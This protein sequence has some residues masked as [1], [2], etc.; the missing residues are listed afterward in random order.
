MPRL[1]DRQTA[2]GQAIASLL[3]RYWEDQAFV[4]DFRRVKEPHRERHEAWCI[5][6]FLF[7]Y[8]MRAALPGDRYRDLLRTSWNTHVL[9]KIEY[10]DLPEDPREL[11]GLVQRVIAGNDS[12]DLLGDLSCFMG[13]S[14]AIARQLQPYFD[15]LADLADRW[16]LRAPWS[17]IGLCSYD[18]FITWSEMP[19]ML[20][21]RGVNLPSDIPKKLPTEVE[22]DPEGSFDILECLVPPWDS[23]PPLRLELHAQTLTSLD[24]NNI[25]RAVR[26]KVWAFSMELK[27]SGWH[28]TP[29]ATEKHAGW[30]FDHYVLARSFKEIADY[31]CDKPG[32]LDGDAVRKAIRSFS[33]R[34]DCRPCRRRVVY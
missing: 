20:K 10:P 34:I 29:S 22:L 5:T 12:G 15:G 13:L 23:T 17:V 21:D 19:Q 11:E 28:E 32:G 4:A 24:S 31:A 2:K 16:N 14:N 1:V 33:A 9:N 27:A 26:R 3:A 6:T 30:W 25:M 7:W 18:A 8:R